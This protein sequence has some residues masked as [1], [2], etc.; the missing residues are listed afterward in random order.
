MANTDTIYIA[1][2]AA[3][4]VNPTSATVFQVTDTV[5]HPTLAAAIYLP[6]YESYPASGT[7]STEAPPSPAINAPQ[8]V[9]QWNVRV[10]GRVTV[11]TSGTFTLAVQYGNSVTQASNTALVTLQSAVTYASAT[12]N[13]VNSFFLTWDP[14]SLL[15]SG[16]TGAGIQGSTRAIPTATVIAGVASVNLIGN[17]VGLVVTALFGTSNTGNIAYLDEFSVEQV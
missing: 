9:T 13:F 14:V 4:L 3:P 11:G 17:K 6:D 8:G 2:N 7:I 12:N 5:A 10:K 1:K 16:S 15:L